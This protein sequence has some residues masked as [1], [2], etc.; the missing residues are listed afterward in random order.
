MSAELPEDGGSRLKGMEL[1]SMYFSDHHHSVPLAVPEKVESLETT[2]FPQ[3]RVGGRL[4]NSNH[5]SSVVVRAKKESMR[6]K[7]Q[8]LLCRYIPEF[9]L[10]KKVKRIVI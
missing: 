8:S 6:R 10:D 1:E 5:L 4:L 3:F 9:C 2:D 7:Q